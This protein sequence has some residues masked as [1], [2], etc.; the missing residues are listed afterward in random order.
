MPTFEPG[1]TVRVP[2]PYTDRPVR[3]RRP[4]LVVSRGSLGNDQNL[5]WVV[6]ITSAENRP[7]PDDLPLGD[8]QAPAGLSAPSVIRSCKIA[9]IEAR[10][11]EPLGCVKPPLLDDVLSVVHGYLGRR[12]NPG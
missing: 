9:T 4:A 7:W 11:V 8:S 1:D 5:L 6:M 12:P 3:Q 10:D 2:F